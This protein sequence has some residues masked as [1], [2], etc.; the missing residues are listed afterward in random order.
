MR[1]ISRYVFTR[2]SS[3]TLYTLI[4][5]LG[6]YGFF[7]VIQ[8]VPHI[9]QNSYNLTVML[10]YVALL[11]PGHAYELMP[12]AVLIGGLVAMT[13]LAT[14]SEYTIIRTSGITLMQIAGMLV[15]MR[16]HTLAPQPHLHPAFRMRLHRHHHAAIGPYRPTRS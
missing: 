1:L 11:I 3:C 6:L 7:D 16:R 8:E 4:A 14:N 10:T 13:Q 9:G 15:P 5:L 2:L 12:L